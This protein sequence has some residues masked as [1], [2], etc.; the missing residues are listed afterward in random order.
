MLFYSLTPTD[1]LRA[2]TI[3]MLGWNKISIQTLQNITKNLVCNSKNM[4]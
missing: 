4:Y 1:D 2:V 3:R